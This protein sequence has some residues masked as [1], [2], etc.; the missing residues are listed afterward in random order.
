M[1]DTAS[2]Q[3]GYSHLQLNYNIRRQLK[4]ALVS[5]CLFSLPVALLL[6]FLA[7]ALSW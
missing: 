1:K 7:G 4:I 2:R 6:N 5:M 3:R